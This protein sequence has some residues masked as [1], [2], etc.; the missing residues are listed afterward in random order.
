VLGVIGECAQ[1][2]KEIIISTKNPTS[3]KY[4]LN[5]NIDLP[6]IAGYAILTFPII[7]SEDIKLQTPNGVL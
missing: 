3:D 4:F 7:E 6:F 2:R 5:S 1:Q